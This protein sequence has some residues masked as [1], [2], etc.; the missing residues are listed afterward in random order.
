ML[1]INSKDDGKKS[2]KLKLFSDKKRYSICNF[3]KSFMKK[4]ND[5]FCFTKED[6]EEIN[7]RVE[8]TK[9]KAKQY[10]KV[11]EK[12]PDFFAIAQQLDSENKKLKSDN[13]LIFQKIEELFNA[14]LINDIKRK[15]EIYKELG[16]DSNN[17]NIDNYI[18]K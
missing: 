5:G 6:L 2:R 17:L 8:E 7:R 1:I 13:F 11:E 15:K 10:E 3:V 4:F 14:D 16:F 18:N 12:L 9:T